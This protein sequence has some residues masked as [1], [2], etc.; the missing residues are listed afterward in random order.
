[1]VLDAM[2]ELVS[3]GFSVQRIPV[4]ALYNINVFILGLRC[5]IVSPLII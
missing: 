1:M 5:M 4:S 3:G 2:H